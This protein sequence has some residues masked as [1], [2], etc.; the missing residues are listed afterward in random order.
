MEIK[1]FSEYAGV[2]KDTLR[3]YE[4]IGL[5]PPVP[6]R[7]GRRDYGDCHERRVAAIQRLKR[8]G[9]TLAEI[10]EY[11]QAERESPRRQALLISARNRLVRHMFELRQSLS[12]LD[13]LLA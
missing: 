3:Y 12:E 9:M 8:S 10:A 5:L 4:R 13:T 2:S 7:R 11:F 6:R 1:A